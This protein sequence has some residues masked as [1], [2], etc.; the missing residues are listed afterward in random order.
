VYIASIKSP[1]TNVKIVRQAKTQV[2]LCALVE[3]EIQYLT[4]Q[5]YLCIHKSILILVLILVIAI[6]LS[7]IAILALLIFFLLIIPYLKYTVFTLN[8][9]AHAWFAWRCK[10]AWMREYDRINAPDARITSR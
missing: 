7:K 2:Y 4:Y 5:T 10:N 6:A 1:T 3:Q 9:I 8:P